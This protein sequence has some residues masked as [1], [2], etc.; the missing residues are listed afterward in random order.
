MAGLPM[1]YKS[2]LQA[3]CSL[4]VKRLDEPTDL[5]EMFNEPLWYNPLIC[6]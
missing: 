4:N 3:W 6:H 2:V 1:F 5:C